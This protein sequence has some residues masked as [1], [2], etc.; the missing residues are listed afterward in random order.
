MWRKRKN[1]I[2]KRDIPQ[3]NVKLREHMWSR[4][5]SVEQEQRIDILATLEIHS[6]S[7]GSNEGLCRTRW[8]AAWYFES[9]LARQSLQVRECNSLA[10]RISVSC[11]DLFVGHPGSDLGIDW[12]FAKSVPASKE[13]QP[14]SPSAG[15]VTSSNFYLGMSR[16]FFTSPL[17][18]LVA[19]ATP[20]QTWDATAWQIIILAFSKWLTLKSFSQH[21]L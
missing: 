6:K 18:A 16:W 8:A 1:R 4:L 2:S 17:V 20:L 21:M 14:H 9:R 5:A 13:Y 19:L 7:I 10:L 11:R 15:I 3:A 12:K